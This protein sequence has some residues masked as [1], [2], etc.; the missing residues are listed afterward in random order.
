MSSSLK[1]IPKV[2]EEEEGEEGRGKVWGER[3]RGKEEGEGEE[4][5]EGEEEDDSPSA[6]VAFL[7]YSTSQSSLPSL[8]QTSERNECF[9]ISRGFLRMKE[10]WWNR[11]L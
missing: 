10:G 4:R 1:L 9:I 3:G 2:G 6:I 11:V 7:Q 5:E 8:E